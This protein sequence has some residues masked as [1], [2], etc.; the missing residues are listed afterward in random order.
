MAIG[1]NQKAAHGGLPGYL[2]QD[3]NALNAPQCDELSPPVSLR[4]ATI[5]K[6]AL[7]SP[8]ARAYW[9][10]CSI[11]NVTMSYDLLST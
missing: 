7:I 5:R 3:T 8:I 10:R 11:L 2:P 9:L 4:I 1:D 6:S